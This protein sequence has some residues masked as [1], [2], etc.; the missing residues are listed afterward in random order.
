MDDLICP[1]MAWTLVV[2]A[3]LMRLGPIFMVS[4]HRDPGTRC[5]AGIGALAGGSLVAAVVMM[6][7]HVITHSIVVSLMAGA[8]VAALALLV[9]GSCI[10][11]PKPDL[12][13]P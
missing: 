3:I 6:I 7:S 4:L 9:A 5:L 1:F 12:P 11:P 8:V 2:G 13:K 10:Q